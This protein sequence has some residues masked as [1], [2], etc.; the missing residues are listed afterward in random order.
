MRLRI[1]V[2]EDEEEARKLLSLLL[3]QRG[4]EVVSAGEPLG[5]PLYNDLDSVCRHQFACGDFLLTDN[6]MPRMTGLQFVARQNERGCKGV[7]HNK[8]VISG[9]WREDELAIAEKLGCQVFTK[10]Y[11]LADIFGWLN[12]CGKAI[13]PDRQLE[14]LGKL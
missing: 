3:R 6:H 11:R 2:L 9:T 1:I 12:K 14:D 4:Y 7:V 5:C 13:P 8:A 10:P